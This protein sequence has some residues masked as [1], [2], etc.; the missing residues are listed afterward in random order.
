MTHE[1]DTSLQDE[2]FRIEEGFW[3]GGKDHFLAHVDEQCLLA[4]PQMGEMH[5]VHSREHV[6]ATATMPNR[7]RDLKI[8][9][10]SLLHP[11][12]DVAIVSYRADV[13]RADGEPYAAL[14]SSAYAKR[15]GGWKLAFHQHS[16]L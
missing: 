11:A 6:A 2:L 4:F 13:V 8:S 7:W 9:G 3:L 1:F 10:R 5:G 16:P 14:V 15:D 12:A